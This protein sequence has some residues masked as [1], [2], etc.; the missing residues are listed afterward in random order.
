M[1]ILAI[2][3]FMNFR[4]LVL[5]T[6]LIVSSCDVPQWGKYDPIGTMY[7]DGLE[8]RERPFYVVFLFTPDVRGL[9]LSNW[10]NNQWGR[11]TSETL[12]SYWS[13]AFQDNQSVDRMRLRF[14]VSVP[15]SLLSTGEWIPNSCIDTVLVFDFF[16]SV[17]YYDEHIRRCYYELV[18]MNLKVKSH[19]RK[20]DRLEYEMDV[21]DTLGFIHH[22]NGLAW[23]YYGHDN[24]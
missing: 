9:T 12:V 1:T 17:S 22:V 5:F 4:K 2:L 8:F 15:D 7:F 11:D 20:I 10:W 6:L 21:T 23:P 18:S 19:D 16:S 13:C 24:Q 3:S 14:L